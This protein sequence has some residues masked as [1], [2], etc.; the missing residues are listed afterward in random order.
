LHLEPGLALLF[1]MDG[2]I[3][4]SGPAHRQAWTIFN[5]RFGLETTEAMHERNF[6]KHNDRIVRDFFGQDLTEEE[7]AARGAA[8]ERVYRETIS[9][10]VG[11]MLV[12]GLR[13]FLDRYR[14]T[15]KAV[16]SNAERPNIDFVLEEAG[17]RP[18]FRAVLDGDQVHKPKPDPEI[19]L[20]AAHLLGVSPQN[21]IVFEDSYSGIAAGRAAGARVVGI[22]TSHEELPGAALTIDDF[23]SG[24]LDAW[25][26]AQ[27]RIA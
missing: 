7:V 2:V 19:Y 12:P 14:E 18:Y 13:Q 9:G 22:R 10:D 25:L 6:G 8:K 24:E 1:D 4:D 26:C 20:R 27:D 21:C 17:L 11:R 23:R 3:I 5:R 16:A 15:P